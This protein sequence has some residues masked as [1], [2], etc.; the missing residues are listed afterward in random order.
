VA[1]LGDVCAS[2]LWDVFVQKTKKILS[3]SKKVVS[4]QPI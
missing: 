2:G 4:L 3:V 1:V